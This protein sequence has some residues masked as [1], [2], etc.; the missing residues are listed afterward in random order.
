M[1]KK[2]K[3]VVLNAGTFGGCF[4]SKRPS[5][6][7][8]AMTKTGFQTHA[9]LMNALWHLCKDN[10]LH[11]EPGSGYV[12][13]TGEG[14]KLAAKLKKPVQ[15]DL[16][17]LFEKPVYEPVEKSLDEEP[18]GTLLDLVDVYKVVLDDL[19]TMRRIGALPTAE[20]RDKTQVKMFEA[21][22]NAGLLSTQ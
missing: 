18:H 10:V 21:L 3:L 13:L 19:E 2:D 5:D 8:M 22:R 6:M 16:F 1:T 7:T 14:Q 9:S 15:F 17:E 11:R 12:I 20:W 4:N